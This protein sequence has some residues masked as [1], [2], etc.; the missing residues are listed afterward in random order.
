[1]K[2]EKKNSRNNKSTENNF[3]PLE[4]ISG[5]FEAKL[6]EVPRRSRGR[7]QLPPNVGFAPAH[8]SLACDKNL[9]P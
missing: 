2:P 7:E 4:I 3:C 8:P 9:C 1:M 5:F 6:V